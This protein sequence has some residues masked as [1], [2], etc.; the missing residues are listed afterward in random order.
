MA[1]LLIMVEIEMRY[2]RE[3]KSVCVGYMP[4]LLRVEKRGNGGNFGREGVHDQ[5]VRCA[6][7][8]IMMILP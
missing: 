8:Y 3:R 2:H 6:C 4:T 5:Y 7:T 1:G